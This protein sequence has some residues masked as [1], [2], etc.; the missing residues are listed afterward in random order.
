MKKHNITNTRNIKN[1]TKRK[2]KTY[3]L[4]N[5]ETTNKYIVLIKYSMRKKL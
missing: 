3:K 1:I 4:K 2:I 5:E